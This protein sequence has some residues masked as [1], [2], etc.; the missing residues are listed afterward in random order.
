MVASQ[1]FFRR[2]WVADSTALTPADTSSSGDDGLKNGLIITGVLLLAVGIVI[3]AVAFVRFRR[4]KREKALAPPAPV[5]PQGEQLGKSSVEPMVEAEIRFEGDGAAVPTMYA[6]PSGTG[7]TTTQA[8][9]QTHDGA[10]PVRHAQPSAVEASSSPETEVRYIS[11]VFQ[12][13]MCSLNRE[14]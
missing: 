11:L 8:V 4:R 1:R 5:V 6:S 3:G 9:Q 7:T 12:R 14:K 10:K 13:V 2:L